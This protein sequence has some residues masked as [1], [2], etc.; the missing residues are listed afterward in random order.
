M[1]GCLLGKYGYTCENTCS[2][3]CNDI[4]CDI[5]SGNCVCAPGYQGGKCLD[6]KCVYCNPT[7]VIK[8][9]K[10]SS[11]SD[12]CILRHPFNGS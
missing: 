8:I 3:H 12:I 11:E 2:T 9:Q 5:W 6:G 7:R 4:T 10:W 1:V